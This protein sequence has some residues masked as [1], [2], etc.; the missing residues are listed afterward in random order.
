LP[1]SAEGA[2]A[3]RA[4]P[5]TAAG[6][7]AAGVSPAAATT[8]TAAAAARL[9]A[10]LSAAEAALVESILG[11]PSTAE[12]AARAA[13]IRDRGHPRFMTFSPKVRRSRGRVASIHLG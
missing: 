2:A 7:P 10:P 9:Q 11:A 12:L 3:A 6:P 5:V 4:R 8:A 1:A 13:A